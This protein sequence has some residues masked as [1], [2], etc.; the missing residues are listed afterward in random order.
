MTFTNLVSDDLLP[1]QQDIYVHDEDNNA[2]HLSQI[3]VTELHAD[4]QKVDTG[5]RLTSDINTE[6]SN[7]LSN[8]TSNCDELYEHVESLQTH[9]EQLAKMLVETRHNRKLTC[10]QYFQCSVINQYLQMVHEEGLTRMNA[11]KAIANAQTH[12]RAGNEWKAKLI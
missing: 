12:W 9:L 1:S 10:F 5:G 3:K 6:V 11:S 7:E 2:V 4:C 8:D